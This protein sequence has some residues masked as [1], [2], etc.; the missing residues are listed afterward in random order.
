MTTTEKLQLIPAIYEPTLSPS[1]KPLLRLNCPTHVSIDLEN[2]EITKTEN[3]IEIRVGYTF[4]YLSTI[5]QHATI[6]IL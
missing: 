2:A 4:I 5:H 1:N 6:V 3:A